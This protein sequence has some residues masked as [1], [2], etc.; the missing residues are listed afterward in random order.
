MS[1]E[2]IRNLLCDAQDEEW[3][4]QCNEDFRIHP[5][6]NIADARARAAEAG[7]T[8]PSRNVDHCPKHKQE[9]KP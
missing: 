7:W 4:L 5:S 9:G 2:L 8:H 3:D 6:E 1:W